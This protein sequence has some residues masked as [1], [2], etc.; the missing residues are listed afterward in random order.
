MTRAVVTVEY[1][2]G[3]DQLVR[4]FGEDAREYCNSVLCD[5]TSA[6]REV[7]FERLQKDPDDLGMFDFHRVV[8]VKMERE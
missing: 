7:L 3:R 4:E 6:Y 1:T 2:L 8:D 5:T